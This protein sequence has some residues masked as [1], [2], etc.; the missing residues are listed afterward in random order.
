LEF[1]LLTDVIA[2]FVRT[3]YFLSSLTLTRSVSLSCSRRT[4]HI[5]HD[6]LT[7]CDL[8]HTGDFFR[9]SVLKTKPGLRQKIAGAV[10][11][12]EKGSATAVKLVASPCNGG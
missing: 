5:S 6:P 9:N 1:L 7:K 10:R 2:L 4:T 8:A 11:R 3:L 12:G